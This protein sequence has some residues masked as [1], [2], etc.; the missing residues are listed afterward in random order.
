VP[1]VCETATLLA[2]EL[3]TNAVVHATSAF[4]VTVLYP[5]PAGRVRIEVVDGNPA[6]PMPLRPPPTA[7]RGRGLLLVDSLSDEWGFQECAGHDGKTIWF[8]LTP[9]V[10]ARTGPF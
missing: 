9:A 10:A 1:E 4:T 5:T 8:E 3:A 7:P 2:S 6:H